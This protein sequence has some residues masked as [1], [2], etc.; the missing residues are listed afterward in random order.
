MGRQAF[1]YLSLI[2]GGALVAVPAEGGDAPADQKPLEGKWLLVSSEQEG[3]S[4]PAEELKGGGTY[5][6]F[7]NQEVIARSEDQSVSLGTYSL[8]PS[9]S[10][11]WYNRVMPDGTERLG[12]YRIEGD[13][14]FLCLGERGKTRPSEFRTTKEDKASLVIYKRVKE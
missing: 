7:E 3:V 2:V 10:P 4:K 6:I 9:K 14:L 8:D 1:L 13:Q 5:M 11:S 12:I